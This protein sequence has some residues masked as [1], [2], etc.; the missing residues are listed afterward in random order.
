MKTI[1]SGGT[2]VCI[3]GSTIIFF[4]N[5][6]END[7]FCMFFSVSVPRVQDP[8]DNLSFH[9]RF[10]HTP[11]LFATIHPPKRREKEEKEKE[12]R[13]YR[14]PLQTPPSHRLPQQPI[15][16]IRQLDQILPTRPSPLHDI[17]NDKRN[18]RPRDSRI[19]NQRLRI[20]Q[21]LRRIPKTKSQIIKSQQYQYKIGRKFGD[22]RL[23]GIFDLGDCA[24]ADGEMIAVGEVVGGVFAVDAEWGVF[25]REAVETRSRGRGG[26]VGFGGSEVGADEVNG[27]ILLLLFLLG[28]GGGGGGLGLEPLPDAVAP[29]EVSFVAVR[30]RVADDEDAEGIENVFGLFGG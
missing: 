12:K 3:L 19:V 11:S 8:H 28:F 18:I 7:L 1:V 4:T 15:I 17:P 27:E 10:Y 22:N 21:R 13:T 5:W 9:F 25:F 16:F 29:G 26:E 24:A 20:L 6:G 2:V 30:D 14:R 23:D